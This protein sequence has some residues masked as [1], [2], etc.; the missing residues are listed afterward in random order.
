MTRP[1]W[2]TQL[3]SL[4]QSC[5]PNIPPHV[6]VRTLSERQIRDI[7]IDAI[8]TRDTW[9]RGL[10]PEVKLK[11]KETF[12]LPSEAQH[13]AYTQQK[14][15]PGARWLFLSPDRNHLNAFDL[16]D[17]GRRVWSHNIRDE[18]ESKEGQEGPLVWDLQTTA[19]GSVVLAYAE[20]KPVVANTL[21][22]TL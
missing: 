2:L 1:V 6:D 8:R 16:Y 10:V 5:V 19:S 20:E 11:A 22:Q 3:A 7:V 4:N 18:T 12:T 9:T 13:T 14:L 17:N 15:S 21:I